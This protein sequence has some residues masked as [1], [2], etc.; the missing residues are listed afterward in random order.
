MTAALGLAQLSPGFT[1]EDAKVP[2]PGSEYTHSEDQAL[3]PNGKGNQ[4]IEGFSPFRV[5]EYFRLF[6]G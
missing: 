4:K 5:K 6:C 1:P 3:W 2:G